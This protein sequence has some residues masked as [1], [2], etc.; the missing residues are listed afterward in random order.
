MRAWWTFWAT[1]LLGAVLWI[2][3]P[4]VAGRTGFRAVLDDPLG[5]A[6]LLLP[7]VAGGV[8]LILFR[9]THETVCRVEAQR[10]RFFRAIAGDG[11]SAR[12]FGVTG[13]VL[14]AVAVAVLAVRWLGAP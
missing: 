1:A 9:R 5:L 2:A 12:A 4:L 10:H 3:V 8:N 13:L 6:A 7:L 11:Y 14:L